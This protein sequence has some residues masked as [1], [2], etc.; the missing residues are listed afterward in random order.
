M[1]LLGKKLKQQK[2]MRERAKKPRRKQEYTPVEVDTGLDDERGG[3]ENDGEE[4]SIKMKKTK[5]LPA[6][7]VKSKTPPTPPSKKSP[8]RDRSEVGSTTSLGKSAKTSAK[9]PP[10]KV[11]SLSDSGSVGGQL[12]SSGSLSGSTSTGLALLQEINEK[13]RAK[14]KNKAAVAAAITQ[15]LTP[16]PSAVGGH[17]SPSTTPRAV[18]LASRSAQELDR[19]GEEEEE[20]GVC[21]PMYANTGEVMQPHPHDDSKSG[22]ENYNFDNSQAPPPQ[23]GGGGGGGPG[24][25]YQNFEFLAQKKQPPP[26]VKKK[27]PKPTAGRS[28]DG[29]E[30]KGRGPATPLKP[31]GTGVGGGRSP[32]VGARKA[33][34]LNGSVGNSCPP[35]SEGEL[36]YQ[37]TDFSRKH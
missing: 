31:A 15:T 14:S 25:E 1:E 5:P 30:P 35:S 23:G 13:R 29:A 10:V 2:E 19:L 4:P 22:Y 27:K 24:S 28:V 9:G 32:N 36:I 11:G 33:G 8:D 7:P 6:P 12:A 18:Q 17:R 20:G 26:Q 16:P 3:F 37:N 21:E 34:H